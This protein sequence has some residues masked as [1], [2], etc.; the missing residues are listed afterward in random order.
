MSPIRNEQRCCSTAETLLAV[1]RMCC[2]LAVLQQL[3]IYAAKSSAEQLFGTNMTAV[4][5]RHL[6][7][8]Y[9][10]KVLHDTAKRLQKI[11]KCMV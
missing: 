2:K 4:L 10:N 11:Q 1:L 8:E 5:Q 6:K 3:Q 9:H 7:H